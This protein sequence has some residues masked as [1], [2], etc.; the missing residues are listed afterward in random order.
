MESREGK[1]SER[2][3]IK[4]NSKPCGQKELHIRIRDDPDIFHSDCRQNQL[5]VKCKEWIFGTCQAT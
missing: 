3:N 1:M 4:V 5:L 2:G